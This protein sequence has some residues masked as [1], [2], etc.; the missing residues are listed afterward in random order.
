MV[1]QLLSLFSSSTQE[2]VNSTEKPSTSDL[3]SLQFSLILIKYMLKHGREK[4]S[5]QFQLIATA[6][7]I[8]SASIGCR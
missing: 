6:D 1:K 5:L 4:I 8:E 2:N 7:K 3:I